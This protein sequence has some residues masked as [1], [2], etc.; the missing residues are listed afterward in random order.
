MSQSGER[1]SDDNGEE[2]LS[3]H[4][5]P[6]AGSGEWTLPRPAVLRLVRPVTGSRFASRPQT[7]APEPAAEAAV[8]EPPAVEA[9]EAGAAEAA[10][11]PVI[12][13]DA[14]EAAG[15]DER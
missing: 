5:T 6:S 1:R 8:A 10:E 15:T 3:P 4:C 12:P 9:A 14:A 7:S 13:A 2:F 11:A